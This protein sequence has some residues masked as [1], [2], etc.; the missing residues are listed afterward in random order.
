LKVRRVERFARLDL[1]AIDEGAHAHHAVLIR[2]FVDF[3]RAKVA[4]GGAE[5]AVVV[6]SRVAELQI[7][8]GAVSAWHGRLHL[9]AGDFDPAVRDCSCSQEGEGGNDACA[10]TQ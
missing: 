6:V 2:H 7:E 10:C 3:N 9:R 4:C 1:Q 5:Q 8:D